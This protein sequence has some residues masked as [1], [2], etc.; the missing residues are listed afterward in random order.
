M[1]IRRRIWSENSNRGKYQPDQSFVLFDVKIGH[2]WLQRSDVENIAEKFGIE[3]VP[4]IGKGTLQEM[5]EMARQGFQSE[6]GHFIAEGIVARPKVELK[7]RNGQR[8]I[9]KIKYGDFKR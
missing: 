9:T 6:W 3:A 4:I 5:I 8:I 2:W 7:A 1:F